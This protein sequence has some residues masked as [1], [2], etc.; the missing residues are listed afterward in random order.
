MLRPDVHRV[1]HLLRLCVNNRHGPVPRI[2]RPHFQPIRS[3]IDCLRPLPY[4]DHC[5]EPF[6]FVRRRHHRRHRIRIHVRRVNRV[7]FP[8][9]HQHVRPVLSNLVYPIHS[10]RRKIVPR[11]L[12]ASFGCEP[13]LSI[14][15]LHPVRTNQIPKRLAMRPCQVRQ[16]H[17][18]GFFLRSQINQ[19]DRRSILMLPII[20]CHRRF[21]VRTRRHFVRYRP[22]LYLRHDFQRHRIHDRQLAVRLVQHQQRRPRRL[23]LP[24]THCRHSQPSHRRRRDDSGNP[25]AHFLA[26]HP[27]LPLHTLCCF[28]ISHS[29]IPEKKKARSLRRALSPLFF[30]GLTTCFRGTSGF[31]LPSAAAPELRPTLGSK[32]KRCSAAGATHPSVLRANLPPQH[33]ERHLPHLAIRFCAP[34]FFHATHHRHGHVVRA[35]RSLMFQRVCD[36]PEVNHQL[37]GQQRSLHRYTRSPPKRQHHRRENEQRA[38]SHEQWKARHRNAHHPVRSVHHCHHDHHDPPPLLGCSRLHFLP[39]LCPLFSIP[40]SRSPRIS[41]FSGLSFL[42]LLGPSPVPAHAANNNIALPVSSNSSPRLVSSSH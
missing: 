40:H 26:S 33:R 30:S 23:S 17:T 16:F 37:I 39:F 36:S 7:S 27:Y 24:R 34:H 22:G 42:D 20:C 41:G 9:N 12:L 4:R 8:R 31:L 28:Y 25:V 18:M 5:V 14:K 19:A 32:T 13:H 11:N 2:P 6:L 21:S 3:N 15:K 35:R 29:P 10:I 1:L 38:A